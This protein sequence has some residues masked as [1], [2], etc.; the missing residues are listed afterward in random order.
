[1]K[2]TM[3]ERRLTTEGRQRRSGSEG[4]WSWRA[5][6]T[7]PAQQ[8]VHAKDRNPQA[9]LSAHSP[10]TLAVPL[11]ARLTHYVSCALDVWGHRLSF[12]DKA[13]FKT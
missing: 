2:R 12:R 8:E 1:M 11:L 9:D 7:F 6:L 3:R 10:A 13:A 5:R 4:R